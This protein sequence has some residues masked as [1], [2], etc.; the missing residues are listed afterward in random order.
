MEYTKTDKIIS[1]KKDLGHLIWW[2][3]KDKRK[4]LSDEAIVEA[5]LSS[6]TEYEVSRL[7]QTFGVE[8][9][10]AIFRK[11]ISQ[12]RINYREST[13]HFFS[14]YFDYHVPLHS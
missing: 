14:L 6:G 1:I 7:F 5:I 12:P 13:Q 4:N 8:Q 9:V 2:V 10:A 11:Q 3:A